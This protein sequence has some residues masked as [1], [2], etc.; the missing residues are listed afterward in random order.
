M[1]G[2][3]KYDRQAASIIGMK[4]AREHA[5]ANYRDSLGGRAHCKM[6]FHFF[7]SISLAYSFLSPN[8]PTQNGDTPAARARARERDE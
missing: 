8:S 3:V 7:P 5:I 2:D 1:T 6:A 4:H